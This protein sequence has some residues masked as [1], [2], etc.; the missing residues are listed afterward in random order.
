MPGQTKHI[1]THELHTA[2]S[3]RIIGHG[4]VYCA[5]RFL[6]IAEPCEAHGNKGPLPN[7]PHCMH[8]TGC[9]FVIPPAVSSCGVQGWNWCLSKDRSVAEFSEAF[10]RPKLG[11]L[12]RAYGWDVAF[13]VGW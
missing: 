5:A 4:L 8:R 6:H 1:N 7:S 10:A 13:E 2:R 9:H 11:G 3:C 12:L